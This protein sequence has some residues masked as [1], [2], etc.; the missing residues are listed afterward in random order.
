MNRLKRILSKFFWRGLLLGTLLGIFVA[1]CNYW[2]VS[3]TA[4]LLY[5]ELSEVP[6]A[7][8][9]L[10]LGTSRSVNGRWE[11]LFFTYRINTAARLFHL[12]KVRHLIVS[13]D[14]PNPKY[15][16]PLD[17]K[18]AL[19]AL[20]VPDSCITMDFAGRRTLDSVLRLRDI[21]GQK[22]AIVVS[23]EFHNYRA[24][25]LARAFGIEALAVNAK[26]PEHG[27]QSTLV[28]E[29]A[30]RVKAVLDVYLLHTKPKIMGKPEPI[31]LS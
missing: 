16:E 9:G 1:G 18:K 3:S 5:D 17:M 26:F 24:V 27:A 6:P 13:G 25:F 20:G 14:N 8:V 29:W 28:R 15:N 12:K 31:D 4:P 30:A 21:F 2:V 23:Q 11:N 7:D 19:K 10:V 22:R